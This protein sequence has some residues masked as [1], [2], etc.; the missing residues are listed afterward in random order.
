MRVDAASMLDYRHHKEH[1]S[2]SY[3]GGLGRVQ[4]GLRKLECSFRGI[5]VRSICVFSCVCVCPRESLR[6]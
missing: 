5:F 6:A 1:L 4:E 3:K 2:R